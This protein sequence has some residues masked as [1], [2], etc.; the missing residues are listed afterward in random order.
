MH[1]SLWSPSANSEHA[2]EVVDKLNK[3]HCVRIATSGDF[4][5]VQVS[6]HEFTNDEPIKASAD[7]APLGICR[8]AWKRAR[9]AAEQEVRSAIGI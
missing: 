4:V 8:A 9:L 3:T 6:P 7:N 1:P 2:W 5:S